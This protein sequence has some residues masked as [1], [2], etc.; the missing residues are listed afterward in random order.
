MKTALTSTFKLLVVA[1]ALSASAAASAQSA[2]TWSVALGVNQVTPKVDSGTLTAPTIP[3]VKN[4]VGKD[5]QPLL[6]INYAITDN[7]TAST[8]IGTPYKH[9]Q[10]GAGS[11]QGVGKIG[12][13][14]SLPA[15]LLAQ[16]HFFDAKAKFRPYVGAGITYAYFRNETGSGVLTALANTGG[17]PTTFKAESAWGSTIKIGANYSFTDKWFAGLSVSKTYVKTTSRFS[18]GQTISMSLD[19]VSVVASVGY[20]F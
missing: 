7:I 12:T 15:T 9:D 20:H 11:L 2:G 16:Y 1:A 13:V 4:E 10:I 3:G 19:P 17:T 5:T 8:F 14:E 6:I 18:T